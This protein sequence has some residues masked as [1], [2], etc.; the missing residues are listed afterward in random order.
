M[1]NIAVLIYDLKVEYHITVVNGIMDYFRDKDDVNVFISP[2]NVP[3]ATTYDY[4]YQYWT[5]VDVLKSKEIDAYIVVVNSFTYSYSLERLTKDLKIYGNRPVYSVSVPLNLKNNSYSYISSEKAYFQMIQHLSEKHGCKKFAFFSASLDG[6]PEGTERLESFKK[7]LK[8]N[9]LEFDPDLVFPGD[10]TP[11][12][13]QGYILNTLKTKENVKFDALLCAND[14]MAV[15]AI[16]GLEKLGLK[17]PDDVCVCGFDNADIT[18]RLVP[19][20]STINQNV[21][22]TGY[23]TAELVYKALKTKKNP[24]NAIVNCY[25]IYRQSCGCIKDDNCTSAYYDNDGNYFPHRDVKSAQDSI[26]DNTLNDI[27]NI[28]HML[29]MTDSVNDINEY[30]NNSIKT[31]KRLYI[32]YFAVCVYE[33]EIEV[34]P[35]DEFVVPEKAKLLFLFDDTRNLIKNYYNQDGEPINLAKQLLPK[36]AKSDKKFTYYIVPIFLK[37]KNYGYLIC[38]LPM[39]KYTVYE[40]YIKL[41][42]NT[43]VHSYEYSKSL[44]AREEMLERNRSLNT[45]TRTDEL[46]SLLNRRGFMDYAQ[47]LIDLSNVTETTGCVFFFDLDGLKKINDTYG[48]KM[49]DMALMTAAEVFKESF[50]KADLIGRL[51][52][53]EFAALAPGFSIENVNFLRERINELSVEFSKKNNLPFIISTSLGVVEYNQE[54][55]DLQKLLLEAD[56]LLYLEKEQKHSKRN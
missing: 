39:P 44:T 50:H 24:G 14:Y 17:I 20:V 54:K 32:E 43:F 10:F 11:A 33:N 31:L 47:R 48:H 53:D 15:G 42:V 41:L 27:S 1:K 37:N 28:F 3:H 56:R 49:G 36:D 21:G 9:N 5:A 51:S 46:T 34:N 18:V 8:D 6:S 25:P 2:V 12:S 26:F 19:T 45:Q 40:V 16:N 52:G 22:E 38:S 4:D 23:K 29:N 55:N 13:S 7:G 30:F 35:E